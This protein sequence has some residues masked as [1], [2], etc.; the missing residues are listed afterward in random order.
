MIIKKLFPDIDVVGNESHPRS[1]AFEVSLN[2]KLIYSKFETD[3]F[4]AEKE[5][6]EWF[7]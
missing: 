5:I 4:P 7:I 1:G 2:D 3:T 6:N